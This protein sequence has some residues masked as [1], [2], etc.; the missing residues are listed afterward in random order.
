MLM[1]CWGV[2]FGQPG[3][4]DASFGNSGI[5]TVA[6]DSSSTE[7]YC[8]AQQADGKSI[9][10]GSSIDSV[11]NKFVISRLNVDGTLDSSF[12]IF[13]K[14]TLNFPISINNYA[15]A[16]AIQTDGKIVI[17]GSGKEQTTFS[18]QFLLIRLNITGSLDST[19]GNDG[20]VYTNPGY[21][22]SSIQRIIA[23][24]NGKILVCGFDDPRTPTYSIR[25]CLGQYNSNGTLDSSF[26]INGIAN[27]VTPYIDTR[28]YAM[29]FTSQNKIL[30]AGRVCLDGNCQ[31]ADFAIVRFLNNGLVDSTFGTNGLVSANVIDSVDGGCSVAIQSD[32]KIVMAGFGNS[33]LG[34]IRYKP[35]GITDSTFG[36]NGKVLMNGVAF[37]QI[38]ILSNGKIL[39]TT[40][41]SHVP[42]TPGN[43]KLIEY[44]NDGTINNGFGNIGTV[45]TT[46]PGINAS[47]QT[48]LIQTDGKIVVAGNTTI[49]SKSNFVIARYNLTTLPLHLLT[50]TAK[51]ANN[52]NLLNWTTAQEVNTDRFEIE[53]SSNSRE[54]SKLGVV[55]AG[56]TTYTFTDNNPLKGVNYYRLKMMDKDGQFTYSPI[57]SLTIN[58]SQLTIAIFPNP[59]HNKLQ[60]QIESD[61]KVALK[62][63]IIT[64]DGKVVLSSN[65]SAVEGSMLHSI[66]IAA[67]QSGTYFLRATSGN[68]EQSVVKFEKL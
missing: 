8:S 5:A 52:T 51:R 63:D 68:G 42:G 10:A 65:I 56:N 43:F 45:V 38:H 48:S 19:F 64:Q 66:N 15:N 35:D 22:F 60:L 26:G 33:S 50:F 61:K 31:N 14:K 20:V 54:F 67:L 47:G 21:R 53:R 17:G 62:M 27:I 6:F 49:N 12:G 25:M 41:E 9:I 28:S 59:A 2:G 4:L 30:L 7:A 16:V 3:T 13:G 24:P 11:K 37:P 58:N 36:I 23:K 32:D 57:R 1:M 55:K 34:M 44:N 39:V 40:T 18:Q 29:V 46:L